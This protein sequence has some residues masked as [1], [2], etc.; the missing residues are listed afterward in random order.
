MKPQYSLSSVAPVTA[1]KMADN[2]IKIIYMSP[3]ESMF[4]SPGVDYE[5]NGQ[6][7]RVIIG[8]CRVGD[9]CEV[10]SSADRTERVNDT[11]RKITVNLPYNG[12]KVV[13]AHAD[14]EQSVYP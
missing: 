14:I 13:I 5:V 9:E 10:M 11:D 12:E 1:Q 4:Y 8:R 6:T 2:T 3:P 7:L